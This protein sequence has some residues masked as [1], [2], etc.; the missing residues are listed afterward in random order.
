MSSIPIPGTNQQA[1]L[2]SD[3]TSSAALKI[4]SEV[5]SAILNAPVTTSV[6]VSTTSVLLSANDLNR[7]LLTIYNYSS[8]ELFVKFSNGA[9]IAASGFTTIIPPKG[10]LVL[11]AAGGCKIPIYGIWAAA[12]AAGYAN[13]TSFT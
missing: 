12:D 7:K 8:Q 13:I 9:S 6:P 4:I 5:V 1:V 11:D 3:T 10:C 2:V